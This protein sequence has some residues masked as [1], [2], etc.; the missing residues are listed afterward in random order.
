MGVVLMRVEA[1]ASDDPVLGQ[2]LGSLATDIT[3][4]PERL[5]FG[6]RAVQ[7]I[8]SLVAGVDIGTVLAADGE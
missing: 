1:S 4:L 2:L 5:R 8:Q 6:R 7:R 3:R